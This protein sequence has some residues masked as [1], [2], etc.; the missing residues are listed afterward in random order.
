MGFRYGYCHS[1][2]SVHTNNSEA[3]KSRPPTNYTHIYAATRYIIR[4]SK[5]SRE[6]H[7]NYAIKI[8]CHKLTKRM[9]NF[10]VFPHRR[11]F[12]EN[13]HASLGCAGISLLWFVYYLVLF[14]HAQLHELR[15]ANIAYVH[16][17]T[18]MHSKVLVIRVLFTKFC[19]AL[20][21]R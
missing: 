2:F 20:C 18:I 4:Q 14:Q 15:A 3:P 9:L 12:V 6:K 8:L 19:A 17:I 13:F 10:D 11:P 21:T 1:N 7:R 5:F 16:R